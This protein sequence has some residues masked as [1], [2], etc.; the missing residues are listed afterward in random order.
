[1]ETL[2]SRPWSDQRLGVTLSP[3]LAREVARAL[4]I[5]LACELDHPFQGPLP[6]RGD[7][8]RL[9]TV[10]DLCVDQLDALSW[11]EPVGEVRMIAP[12]R[13][14]EVIAKE[15]HEGGREH[16]EHPVGWNAPEAHRARRQGR[17]MIRAAQA[18]D[19]ALASAQ[20]QLASYRNAAPGPD[21]VCM[22]LT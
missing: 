13:L 10:V 12:R 5:Q 22:I 9:R 19:A 20:D 3:L 15:L 4:R 6:T 18:I 1:M 7:A 21:E 8:A 14:L 11:G 2:P 17:R 16:L